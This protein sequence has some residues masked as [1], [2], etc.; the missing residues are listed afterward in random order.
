MLV[1]PER[2]P[3]VSDKQEYLNLVARLTSA[4]ASALC[5]RMYNGNEDRLEQCEPIVKKVL[6]EELWVEWNQKEKEFSSG[7][8]ALRHQI[9]DLIERIVCCETV[10][11][12]ANDIMTSSAAAYH[13]VLHESSTKSVPIMD[14]Q[15][16][17]NAKLLSQDIANS[18]SELRNRISSQPRW[19]ASPTAPGLYVMMANHEAQAA[20]VMAVRKITDVFGRESCEAT[21][22]VTVM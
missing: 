22:F 3:I 12:V 2:M 14:K 6:R 10:I 15:L 11:A 13:R 7:I 21:N 8:N 17:E 20:T 19:L 1:E 9:D 16:V 4:V 5:E 18:E